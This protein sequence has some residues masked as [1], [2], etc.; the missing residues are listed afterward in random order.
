MKTYPTSNIRNVAVL[1]HSGSGK[2]TLTE[3]MAYNAGIIDR[4]GRV[5]DG[6]TISDYDSEEAKR[7]ISINAASVPLEYGGHKINIIDVPGYFDFLGESVSSLRV[8]DGAVLV[9]DALSGIEVGTEKSW[10]MVS[11][12]NIPA[13]LV[14]NKMDRENVRFEKIMDELK[15]KFGNKIVPFEI[16]YGE[17]LD[18][19][20][21]INVVDM[22]GRERKGDRCFDMDVPEGM[23]PEIEPFREMIMESVAQSDESLMEKYF[24]GEELTNAEIHA[25]L[26][27]GVLEGEL[28]PVLCASGTRNTGIETLM[29]M[30]IE[31]FP[32]PED[33]EGETFKDSKGNDGVK[34]YD[35]GDSTSAF[36]FKTIADPYVGRLSLFKVVS[37]SL[38]PGM[39]LLNTGKNKK[40]KINHIYILRGK[41]QIEVENLQAGDIGAF[42]K[43]ADTTTGDTL[44]DPKDPVAFHPIVFPAPVIALGVEPKSKGDEDKIGSGLTKLQEEDQTLH[45]ERNTETK[46]TLISG[47]G[48]M[49]IEIVCEKLKNKFGIEVSLADPK[50]PYRETIK[51]KATSEGKHKKQSGGRGQFGHVYI[52]F[53]PLGDTDIDFEF[54]DKVVGGAVPRNFIPAV[55]K[56]LRDCIKEGVLAKYPVVGLRATLFDGSYHAVDSDEMSFKMAASI[57]YKKGLKE[58]SPVIL[59]PVY[60]VDITIPEDYMG[61]IMGDLNKKRGRILGMEPVEGGKQK[62]L[63][64]A[65]LAEMFKYAT[66]LRS[67]TQAR[68]DFA[69]SFAR[70]EEL[71]TALADKVIEA[72]KKEEN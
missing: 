62:I 50:I 24:A 61:D 20:G 47:L 28:I 23:K 21:V 12:R 6:N 5:E 59:E 15:E 3:A 13:I 45:V 48:E 42:S 54:V 57:A 31:Y 7:I 67:M 16:P 4:M 38:R 43:L 34:K 56:G 32:S 49:H 36:V 55:E 63:A 69:M 8:A 37:G 33:T 46:Q 27:K 70:Y 29:S 58:A 9:L 66:E 19:N 11:K 60:S 51:S 40:E 72:S 14:V 68:G 25:G 65:P 2:T 17:G 30:I 39:E 44:C 1:G 35:A 22:K 26:R 52:N 53:E 18:F 71:P 10:E 64:E 41:K